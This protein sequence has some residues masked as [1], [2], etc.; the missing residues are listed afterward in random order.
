[1]TLWPEEYEGMRAEARA[2]ATAIA[3]MFGAAAVEGSGVDRSRRAC[4][5]NGR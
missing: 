3:E 1:M 4:A 5:D 2:T